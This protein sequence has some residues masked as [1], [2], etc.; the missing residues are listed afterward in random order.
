[1]GYMRYNRSRQG[2]KSGIGQKYSYF[3]HMFQKSEFLPILKDRLAVFLLAGIVV[4]SLVIVAISL[5]RL[6]A[7][8]VQVPVRY[9]D[10]GITNIYRD[11]WYA[12]LGFTGFGL[13]TL[14]LNGFLSIKMY[15]HSRAVALGFMA[16][17]LVVVAIGI[18][19]TSAVFHLAALSA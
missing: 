19:V 9:S 11:K 4:C 14:L 17:S 10:Y 2:H 3:I 8:D 18:I 1:M 5:L 16:L 13:M 7:S 12:L 15:A 6:Q